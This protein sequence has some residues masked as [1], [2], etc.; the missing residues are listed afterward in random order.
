VDDK[1]T[2]MR[3][4]STPTR[5]F[6]RAVLFDFDGTLGDS[7]PA[8][9]ASVN[10]VR[11]LNDLP[12]LT[13]AEVRPHVG[14]GPANLLEQTVP[15][16]DNA[17]NVAAYRA[18]HPSVLHSGTR[19]MPGAAEL[20]RGLHERGLGLAVTSNKLV[21]FT[22]DLLTYLGVAMYFQAVLGPEDVVHPKPAPD[23]LLAA[24]PRLGVSAAE[25][26]YIGDMVIDIETARGAGV[27]VWTV[28]TGSDDAETLARGRPDR[29]FRDLHEVASALV[30]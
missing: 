11:A 1:E 23:M 14:R 20:V 7:Y 22:R 18:H 8:I 26:L 21:G 28:A 29:L 5:P 6:P 25:A 16:G 13:E 2:T 3:D 4:A 27:S 15:R 24:L 17:A 19:L 30:A 9:T 10:Q 12:P